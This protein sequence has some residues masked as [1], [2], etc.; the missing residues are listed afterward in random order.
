MGLFLIYIV[1]ICSTMVQFIEDYTTRFLQECAAEFYLSFLDA[2]GRR[3]HK[4]ECQSYL[5][6][7]LG[8][9]SES[10]FVLVRLSRF[11]SC[12]PIAIQF[13]RHSWTRAAA[14]GILCIF[15]LLFVIC[16]PSDYDARNGLQKCDIQ[17]CP[18]WQTTAFEEFFWEQCEDYI[19]KPKKEKPCV[20]TGIR[21]GPC[22]SN[23]LVLSMGPM[24][25]EGRCATALQ[26]HP[27]TESYR[28]FNNI[29]TPSHTGSST[30]SIQRFIQALQQHPYTVIQ[31]LQQHPYT[32]SYMLF[33]NIHTQSYRLFNNIHTQSHTG[34]STTS[35]HRVIQ[36]LQQHPYTESYRLFNNIHTPSHTGSSTTSIHRVI[37]ALQQ[38]PYTESYM[39]FNNIHTQSYMFFNNIHTPSYTSFYY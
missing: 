13:V 29:H 24:I 17:R 34:S 21:A 33:N 23:T 18:R 30:T 27:Y 1:H 14:D 12:L 35:I 19:E 38:H 20:D 3:V 16:V 32:E 37:H 15:R 8:T 28:L 4:R 31:A 2:T 39:L 6:I 26:Q 5:A 25:L 7:V 11:C 10:V 9:S 36:A 22:Q